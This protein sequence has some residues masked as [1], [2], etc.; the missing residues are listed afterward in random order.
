MEVK[1]KMGKYLQKIGALLILT[2]FLLSIVP[3]VLAEETDNT[4][5]NDGT[6]TNDNNVS[7]DVDTNKDV[8]VENTDVDDSNVKKAPKLIKAAKPQL[9][10]EQAEKK[11]V[12]AKKQIEKA[13]DRYLQ[14]KEKYA[15]ARK[16]HLENKEK[17]LQM[18]KD[19]KSCISDKK[20]C[21]TI[22][23]NLR[24]GVENHLIKTS[25]VILRSLEKLSEHVENA[26]NLDEADK[27][28]VLSDISELK[29]KVNDLND[30]VEALGSEATKEAIKEEIDNLKEL[31][32]EARILQK[33]TVGLLVN[34]KLQN[35]INKLDEIHNSMQYR[36]DNLEE[37]GADSSDLAELKDLMAEYDKKVEVVK[38][39]YETAKEKWKGIDSYS[40]FDKFIRDLRDAQ[41]KVRDDLKDTREA[42]RNFMD[43][44]R[45]IVKN[46]NT[47]VTS[48]ED[49]S[50]EAA[51]EEVIS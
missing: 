50:E 37:K 36:I 38:G 49:T 43:K 1:T 40:D 11:L 10:K 9:I 51:S 45:E 28:E 13:R 42:V 46:L 3:A 31:A 41:N 25:D 39:D 32:K 24:Y 22:K 44:H 48:L 30:R 26:E 2:I 47:E 21:E 16:A 33:R 8:S 19:L 34:T 35:F 12:E 20:D 5:T 23:M 7:D 15:E 4:I 18:N 29:G 17:L 27:E 6:E 14:A